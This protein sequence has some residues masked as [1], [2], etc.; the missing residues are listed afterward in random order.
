MSRN[1]PIPDATQS[2]SQVPGASPNNHV[3]LAI[4]TAF[5]R[6]LPLHFSHHDGLYNSDQL[7]T[8][9]SEGNVEV[10][11][12][13]LSQHLAADSH[14]LDSNFGPVS[15]VVNAPSNLEGLHTASSPLDAEFRV[16]EELFRALPA[17]SSRPSTRPGA[18]PAL[19]DLSDTPSSHETFHSVHG[20]PSTTPGSSQQRMSRATSAVSTAL[21]DEILSG[22]FLEGVEIP[23]DDDCLHDDSVYDFTLSEFDDLTDPQLVVDRAR[24]LAFVDL[25][26]DDL[27]F[28]Q[29][30]LVLSADHRRSYGLSESQTQTYTLGVDVLS[31]TRPQSDGSKLS[32]YQAQRNLLVSASGSST[33]DPRSSQGSSNHLSPL[34]SP[35][36]S[37]LQQRLNQAKAAARIRSSHGGGFPSQ[38]SKEI[39]SSPGG[40]LLDEHHN[41]HNQLLS[42]S[43][44]GSPDIFCFPLTPPIHNFV[45]VGQS[46]IFP[47]ITIAVND[48]C[49]PDAAVG[50]Y[51]QVYPRSFNPRACRPVLTS[52]LFQDVEAQASAANAALRKPY[53][54][55]AEGNSKKI[56]G[57]KKTISVTHIGAPKLLS[58]SV[59]LPGLQLEGGAVDTGCAP[60]HHSKSILKGGFKLRLN[61]KKPS[62]SANNWRTSAGDPPKHAKSTQNRRGSL[63]QPVSPSSPKH[64][65]ALTSF[66]KLVNTVSAFKYNHTPGH[67]T[68][69]ISTISEVAPD[70]QTFHFCPSG[71][72]IVPAGTAYEQDTSP[73]NSTG[74]DPID[75]SA[76]LARY[77]NNE[78][79][80]PPGP[81]G[82]WQARNSEESERQGDYGSI[83]DLYGSDSCIPPPR[84]N[85]SSSL[86]HFTYQPDIS[87]PISVAPSSYQHS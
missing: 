28:I 5:E 46:E 20:S 4:S 12:Q 69:S 24:R 2:S 55:D 84:Q 31:P 75:M 49:R 35:R 64:T 50:E 56:G 18:F 32:S 10:L 78:D 42:P 61:K 54:L 83:L 57:R 33:L 17:T 22:I 59:A 45:G 15:T 40:S 85:R 67:S 27:L 63:D 68:N 6:Q 21:S 74:S 7:D 72:F 60:T 48:T 51:G 3:G 73:P 77:D 62:E 79:L 53:K 41:V 65:P 14:I 36:S 76:G 25:A 23:I 70:D 87:K 16:H 11:H 86:S 1:T 30:Q 52:I 39:R 82:T 44:S 80:I 26:Y 13:A 37:A 58:A 81:V 71:N 19:E 66:R 47:P 8:D 34:L 38:S 9:G 29:K 43:S